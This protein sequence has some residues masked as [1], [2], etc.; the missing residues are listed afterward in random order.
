MSSL[1][2]SLVPHETQL[3]L[4]LSKDSSQ[5]LLRATLPLLPAQ[6][7]A[8]TLLLEALVVWFGLPLCA[9]LDADAEDV[10]LRPEFWARF[11]ADTDSPHITVEWTSV[12]TP[13][14][15]R[16]LRGVR[17]APRAGRSR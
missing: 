1:S 11:C 10:L 15:A 4:S 2:L 9:V 7:Q 8:L 3:F 16:F 6:P 5:P 17:R 12:P 14:R 13:Q